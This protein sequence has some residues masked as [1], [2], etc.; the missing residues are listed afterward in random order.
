MQPRDLPDMDIEQ[1][2]AL[3]CDRHGCESRRLLQI[4]ID[5]QET[6]GFLP[7][8]AL[9][10]IANRLGLPRVNVEG[11]AGFYSFQSI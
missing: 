10:S 7:P 1:K 9:T 3:L 8:E 2:S 11:V 4:L 5:V 6:Y